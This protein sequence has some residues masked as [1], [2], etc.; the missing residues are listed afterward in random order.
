MSETLIKYKVVNIITGE[1][2]L[3]DD[4]YLYP[5][6]TN[7]MIINKIINY[8]YPNT[9]LIP[10]EIYAYSKDEPICFKYD[11]IGLMNSIIKDNRLSDI[12]PDDDFVNEMG[13]QK[14]V[15]ITNKNSGLF[16][17]N[18]I[19][20]NTIYYFSLVEL[21]DVLKLD[22]NSKPNMI[23][24]NLKTGGD[25]KR[26]YNGVIRKFFPNISETMIKNYTDKPDKKEKEYLRIKNLVK[27]N[28]DIF[29]SLNSKIFNDKNLLKEDKLNFKLMKLSTSF[30]DNNNVNITKLFSD[31]PLSEQYF[32]SKLLLEDY[33]DTYFKL[34]EK[35]LKLE[36]STR[37]KLINKKLCKAMLKDYKEY[38]PLN[39]GFV[40]S[41]IKYENIFFIKV[42]TVIKTGNVFFSFILH[43]D[44][45]VDIILN[46]YNNIDIDIKD[47]QQIIGES[48]E[49]IKRINNNRIYSL[50]KIPELVMDENIKLEYYNSEIIYDL[51]N[52]TD[53]KGRYVYKKTNMM[54]FINN[55]YT[56]FRLLKERM[57]LTDD[58]SI[59]IHYKRVS[60][61]ENMDV[62]DSV[63]SALKHPRF[64]Y[65]ND[66]I[67]EIIHGNYG[68]TTESA[69]KVFSQWEEN[70][71]LKEDEGKKTY[72]F[73]SKEPGSEIIMDKYGENTIKFRLFNITSFNELNRI[74]TFIK[75]MMK[76][77]QL[78]VSDKS[79]PLYKELFITINKVT[80]QISKVENKI[81]AP[82]KIKP[83]EVVENS[84]SEEELV[85]EEEDDDD[86]L[87]TASSSSGGGGGGNHGGGGSSESE[88]INIGNY[89]TRKLDSHDSEL[90][91]GRAR[92]CQAS[93][94]KQVIALS[95]D[96]LERVDK[97]DILSF[98][99][100][101]AAE[102]RELMKLSVKE[103]IAEF[104]ID[105]GVVK[106]YSHNIDQPKLTDDSVNVNYIC[107]KYWN[108]RTDLPIH[109]RDIHKYV[110][111]II[112]P[113]VKKGRLDKSV[114]NRTGPQWRN[115]DDD[116]FKKK[117]WIFLNPIKLL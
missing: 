110:D 100:K 76:Q 14:N 65:S 20:D 112:P 9:V 46:N 84:S 111:E 56:H 18:D 51:E 35:S 80:E 90:F 40:P 44:G 52:F 71:T 116:I 64:G 58:D 78:F 55:Y 98:L 97:N 47:L 29:K 25:F 1:G 85:E 27:N 57:D 95:N 12:L 28:Y 104:G 66:Q 22:L 21:L 89:F 94:N 62:F 99:N 48:N 49:I 8:C 88:I 102:K 4:D 114:F 54:N 6:D 81:V 72:R 19:V 33:E 87:S 77:Y 82:I 7:N 63:I 15:Q 24:L 73:A 61:Y 26:F 23:E 45:N 92:L 79:E 75:F 53:D 83:K 91:K 69:R 109:P 59:H 37:D 17:D 115:M 113:G 86:K 3:F 105:E 30:E 70:N 67:I 74:T 34:H 41:F 103:L 11:N 60:D 107:P 10:D 16:E 38:I 68:I 106:S 43:L 96:E 5:D 36:L 42:H 13:T 108:I 117:L 2:F 50:Q 39:V 101:S 93:D 31:F 32:L